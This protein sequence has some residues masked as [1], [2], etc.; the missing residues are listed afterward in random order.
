MQKKTTGTA[1]GFKAFAMPQKISEQSEELLKIGREIK[2]GIAMA[3][4]GY[5]SAVLI[6]GGHFMQGKRKESDEPIGSAG[7]KPQRG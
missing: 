3:N 2:V 5:L 6:A 7:N 4:R 1:G